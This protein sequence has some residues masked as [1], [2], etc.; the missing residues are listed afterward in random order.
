M[1]MKNRT[2]V[3]GGGGYTDAKN[4]SIAPQNNG[5]YCQNLQDT[6]KNRQ[7]TANCKICGN[8]NKNK[9]LAKTHNKNNCTTT[10]FDCTND[11]KSAKMKGSSMKNNNQ[12]ISTICTEQTRANQFRKMTIL[13]LV[14]LLLGLAFVAYTTYSVLKDSKT[15]TGTI[16]FT[17]DSPA[18]RFNNGIEM[19]Y[20]NVGADGTLNN[21]GIT[22]GSS[23]AV[24]LTTDSKYNVTIDD[25]NQLSQYFVKVEYIFSDLSSTTNLISFDSTTYTFGEAS[26]G[27]VS[28]D[29]VL[30]NRFSLTSTTAVKTGTTFNLFEPLS[31]FTY[32]GEN[33]TTATT[34]QT[35]FIV[36][37]ADTKKDMS[38]SR[39]QATIEGQIGFNVVAGSTVSDVSVL[40]DVVIENLYQNGTYQSTT[41]SGSVNVAVTNPAKYTK[42]TMQ[43][44]APLYSQNMVSSSKNGWMY[45]LTTDANGTNLRATNESTLSSIDVTSVLKN[46][47]VG[48]FSATQTNATYTFS[49]SSSV[50]GVNYALMTDASTG[51]AATA[52]LNITIT[53][54]TKPAYTTSGEMKIEISGGFNPSISVT[55]SLT[56]SEL[57]PNVY[58]KMIVNVPLNSVSSSTES[59]TY[60]GN[61]YNCEKIANGSYTY[62]FTII[63]ASK[64]SS[65]DL[66]GLLV[67]CISGDGYRETSDTIT[68]AVE[69]YYSYD[70]K[71]FTSFDESINCV[72]SLSYKVCCI[73]EDTAVS[74]GFN[75]ETKLANEI[76]VG[77]KVLTMDTTTGELS[78]QNITNVVVVTRYSLA[79]VRLK[80]GSVLNLTPDHPILTSTG[81]AI[82]GTS[83]LYDVSPDV[84][85]DNPLAVGDMVKT[86]SGYVEV[87]SID[88]MTTTRGITVYSYSVENNHN[89]FAGGM[90]IHNALCPTVPL[91]A[92]NDI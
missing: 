53:N 10:E 27:V 74:V 21:G 3:L 19:F 56:I 23:S 36:V 38:D 6:C 65:V 52:T 67:Q 82:C 20:S 26:L 61:S 91:N 7:N 12:R 83:T 29:S 57:S 28:A 30:K 35:I 46:A 68:E 16:A 17:F 39:A 50:D 42:I 8:N 2:N 31:H 24:S 66:S 25:Q 45:V 44:T 85:R 37:S 18:L 77:D 1:L 41:V 72:Y 79:T 32:T 54:R 34:P 49:I 92:Y 5:E 33:L 78:L 58:F 89:L 11:K 64:I 88:I 76:E 22:Y 14:I 4:G 47:P 51:A 84:L 71:N 9:N 90:L 80:D 43:S 81:W 62:K 73:T 59:V 70:N 60:G 40:N 13:S 75:G 69:L 48:T 15:A 87:E 55:S 86:L 63:S